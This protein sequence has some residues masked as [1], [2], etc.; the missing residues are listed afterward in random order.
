[1]IIS[2]LILSR[3][4]KKKLRA[5]TDQAC[6]PVLQD[7]ETGRDASKEDSQEVLDNLQLLPLSQEDSA[8]HLPLQALLIQDLT[9]P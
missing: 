1:M 5:D 3:D 6:P 4:S 2:S 7:R 9:V 8:L